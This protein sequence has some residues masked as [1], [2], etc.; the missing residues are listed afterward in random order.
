MH[1][2]AGLSERIP[3]S[4]VHQ[5]G[6]A[7]PAQVSGPFLPPRTR[8]S[9]VIYRT[10]LPS[11]QSLETVR[12]MSWICLHAEACEQAP[13]RRQVLERFP[14]D[15]VANAEEARVRALS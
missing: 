3:G 11:R 6:D 8:L 5:G 7:L 9:A 1:T 10:V 13:A 12:G 14:E 2:A 4:R 15:G